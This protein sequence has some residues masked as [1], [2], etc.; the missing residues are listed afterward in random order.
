MWCTE[1]FFAGLSRAAD[2]EEC[3]WQVWLSHFEVVE[4]KPVQGWATVSHNGEEEQTVRI[5]AVRHLCYMRARNLAD[6]GTVS[7][8]SY[9]DG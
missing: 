6:L 2:W 1:R 9:I 5:T 4:V 8:P 7:R 3:L